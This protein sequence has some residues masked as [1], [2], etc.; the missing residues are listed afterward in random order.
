MLP[1]YSMFIRSTRALLRSILDGLINVGVVFLCVVATL[2]R[3]SSPIIECLAFFYTGGL[4]ALA[5][6]EFHSSGKRYWRVT[7]IFVLAIFVPLIIVGL[8]LYQSRYFSFFA[9][10][11]YTGAL[12]SYAAQDFPWHPRVKNML[13]VA[14]NMTYSSYLIHFPVQLA[15]VLL[16]QTGIPIYSNM[17]FVQYMAITL[18]L[19]YIIY[20][21]FER[22]AQDFIRKRWIA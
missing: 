21:Y 11:I 22:P 14:G 4:S 19:A 13:E 8:K 1:S 15:I 2:M 9:L 3:V 6:L 20:R 7:A 17:F 16:Y 10:L 12:L 18:A 5:T